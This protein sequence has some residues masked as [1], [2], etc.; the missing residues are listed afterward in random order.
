MG[1]FGREVGILLL[2]CCFHCITST[3]PPDTVSDFLSLQQNGEIKRQFN[4]K[5]QKKQRAYYFDG[6]IFC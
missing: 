1:R 5:S 2:L 4:L 3:C 6:N